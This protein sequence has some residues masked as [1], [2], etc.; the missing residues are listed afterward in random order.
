MKPTGISPSRRAFLRTALATT[1]ATLVLAQQFFHPSLGLAAAETAPKAYQPAYFTASEW[2]LL[3]SL[4]DRLIPADEEGPG[5]LEA[6]VPEFIDRQMG[7]PYGYGALWYMQGPFR[8]AP[9]ELGYQLPFT[10]RTLYRAALPAFDKAVQARFGKGLVEL[11]EPTRDDAISQL[12]HGTL[13]I[14]ILPPL[15][16]FDQLLQNTRE[17]YFCDPVHGGN[18]DMAAWRMINFPGAR[19]DYIDWVEQYGREY[20]FRPVSVAVTGG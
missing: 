4:V 16:F 13:T 20:P 5:A 7:E 17:G 3:M 18:K 6:G 8:D 9:A 2:A 12:Q 19:A 10:P 15:V 1:P 11:D 14:G